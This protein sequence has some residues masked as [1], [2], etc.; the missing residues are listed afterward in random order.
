M[1]E[2]GKVYN[3]NKKQYVKMSE[4]YRYVLIYKE[5]KNKTKTASLKSLYKLVYGKNFCID[6]IADIEGEEWKSINEY[7]SISSE[8]RVK[9][10]YNYYA[11]IIKP[12]KTEKGYLKVQIYNGDGTKANKFVHILVATAFE[13]CGR[14]ESDSWQVHHLNEQPNDNRKC[15]LKWVSAEEHIKLHNIAFRK[16]Q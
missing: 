7:Y 5:G 9:S 16:E 15:N 11:I 3:A 13:E 4:H 1:T 6:N 14:P 10:F 8:G 2:D 12:Q